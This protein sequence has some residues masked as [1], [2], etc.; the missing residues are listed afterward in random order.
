MEDA[1]SD[2]VAERRFQVLLTAAFAASALAL[3]CIGVYGVVSWSVA[4]RRN[5]I[6][7]RMVLGSLLFGVSAHDPAIIAGVSFVLATVAA[8]ACYLPARRATL[9]DPLRA[10]R[11][12]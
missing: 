2:S 12:E 8:F 5:E 6:G 10:L 1:V 7:V 9:A 4:R 11:Y 3:A